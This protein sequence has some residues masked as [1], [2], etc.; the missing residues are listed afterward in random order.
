MSSKQKRLI[1]LV[2]PL[3]IFLTGCQQSSVESTGIWNMIV[4]FF[5][6]GIVFF[7]N[8]L[9][10]NIGMGIIIMTLIVR[11]IMVPLYARQIKS[12]E[13]MKLLQ[14]K[15]TKLNKKYENKTTPED[16]RKKG[17]EQQAIYKEAGINPL[18]GCLPLLLQMPLLFAFYASLSYLIPSQAVIDGMKANGQEV[19]YGLKELGVPNMSTDL[20]GINLTEPVIIFALFAGI[21][22]YLTTYLSQLGT[23]NE[24]NPGAGAIKMMMYFMPIMI[25]VIGL[26]LPGALSIYWCVGNLVSIAQ[27]LYYR[28]SHIQTARQKKK[29]I[30]K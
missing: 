12:Q 13:E 14:P 8:I 25:F 3:M 21:T 6:K 23:D 7:G 20:F 2:L 5:A 9:G 28:R 27:T 22:T 30:K 4:I 24:N 1:L 26:R 19:I 16:K 10:S 17:M 18:A 15:I 29:I 11:I